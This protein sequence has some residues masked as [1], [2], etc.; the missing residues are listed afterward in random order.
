MDSPQRF[1]GATCANTGCRGYCDANCVCV[2]ELGVPAAAQLDPPFDYPE[3]AAIGVGPAASMALVFITAFLGTFTGAVAAW[4]LLQLVVWCME[5]V[6]SAPTER[7]PL[8]R[9]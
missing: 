8:L 6:S 4:F 2:L 7:T 9:P 1:R 3:V 5:R